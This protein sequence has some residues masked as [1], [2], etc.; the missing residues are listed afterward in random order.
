MEIIILTGVVLI[1][2][3]VVL[4]TIFIIKETK[5]KRATNGVTGFIT[6]AVLFDIAATSCMMIGTDEDY[7][8]LHGILGYTALF[9]MILDAIFIWKH[10]MKHGRQVPFSARLNRNS[11]LAYVLWLAAFF[12][13]EYIAF[14]KM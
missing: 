3:A 11:K 2:I 12:T 8:T 13:G 9:L 7:F 4:Y 10:R 1:H 14:M 6:A 5:Y